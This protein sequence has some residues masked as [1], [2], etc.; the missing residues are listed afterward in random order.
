MAKD[1]ME[2]SNLT[3]EE[4]EELYYEE[5]D[6]FKEEVIDQEENFNKL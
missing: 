5:I 1:F 2:D 3:R 4:L 6:M